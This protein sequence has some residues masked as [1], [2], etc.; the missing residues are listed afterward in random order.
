MPYYLKSLLVFLLINLSLPYALAGENSQS[1][2]QTIL[3]MGDSISAGFG[4]DK[5]QG[6]VALLESKLKPLATPYKIINASI[7]GET[8]SGGANRIK[9]LLVKHNPCLVIIELG[10]NDGLRGS[11]IKMMKQNLDYM[12]KQSQ[13]AGAEVLLLG[14]RIPPNYGK[15]YSDLFSRQYKQLALENNTLV[16]PFLLNG[17]ATQTGMM[18]ADGIHPT[19]KAQPLMME[20]V[21]SMI[22]P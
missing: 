22:K 7:S 9:P 21:W 19:A 16:L 5:S 15:T 18:Q 11:P 17:I 14:M 1:E 13:N 20:Y 12:I 2:Q 10:G 4:I 6:W 8:T 3:I